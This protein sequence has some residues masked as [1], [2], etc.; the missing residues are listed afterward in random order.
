[1]V[2][3]IMSVFSEPINWLEESIK[4]ILNQSYSNFE[5]IIVCDNPNN[6]D[7]Q[8]EIENYSVK[9]NRIVV[10]KNESNIGLTKSLNKGLLIAKGDYIARMDADDIA[11]LDRFSKQIDFLE[12]N[13]DIS[14]CSSDARVIDENSKLV[15]ETKI[16]GQLIIEDLFKQSPLIHPTVM[17]RRTLLSLR[18]PF[19][20]EVYKISQDYELWTFLYLN[21]VKFGIIKEPLIDYRISKKQI[22]RRNKEI[23]VKN[24]SEIGRSFYIN[25]VKK[26]VPNA[27]E[28]KLEDQLKCLSKN[29]NYI[30]C[31]DYRMYLD[32]LYRQYYTI[33][34]WNVLYAIKYFTDPNRLVQKLPLRKSVY[35]ILGLL[36]KNRYNMFQL[37]I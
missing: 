34:R 12:K 11:H 6:I 3:V 10:I 27:E 32:L 16:N 20:N 8:K 14:I 37:Y 15:A 2:S 17:F 33:S 18:R 25:M 29:M 19:Y 30:P 1:M 22:S 23:Q 7:V 9:D 13:P 26:I 21:K 24:S 35:M 28:L 36:F 5:L 4:S 31:N